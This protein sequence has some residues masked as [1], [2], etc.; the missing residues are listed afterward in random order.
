MK[1]FKII[2]ILKERAGGLFLLSLAVIIVLCL[3]LNF[4][5]AESRNEQELASDKQASDEGQI[6]GETNNISEEA[7]TDSKED[8]QSSIE[9]DIALQDTKV[10]TN[11]TNDDSTIS[12]FDDL[13]N[14]LKKYCNKSGSDNKSKCKKYCLETKGNDRYK[15]LRKKYCENKKNEDKNTN[16]VSQ[17]EEIVGN[18]LNFIVGSKEF[19]IGFEEGESIFDIMKRAKS[20][21]K[22]DFKYDDFGGNLGVLITEINGVKNGND[23]D[24]TQ[25]KYWILY[26]SGKSSSV[27][28]S[29]HKLN[30]SDTSIEWKYEKYS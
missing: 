15:D 30:K 19:K 7:T 27:G 23:S 22:I 28:C 9:A 29:S 24:W 1:M 4:S 10:I 26:V 2:N 6:L 5:Y 16:T 20:Q 13:K 12:A 8:V 18:E 25:N 11:A 21:G 14:H 17:A 3:S